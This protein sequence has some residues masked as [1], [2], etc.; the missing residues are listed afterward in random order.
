M[1]FVFKPEGREPVTIEAEPWKLKHLDQW[2]KKARS[3]YISQAVE[4]AKM[5]D[6]RELQMAL[7]RDAN[8]E[9]LKISLQSKHPATDPALGHPEAMA[10]AIRGAVEAAGKTIDDDTL[11]SLFDDLEGV[12]HCV[13]ELFRCCS[14]AQQFQRIAA[15]AGDTGGGESGT[16]EVGN[17]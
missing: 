9:A 14:Y 11:W 6:D 12:A 15:R 17:A 4:A 7:I 13:G 10:V 2:V 1:Q 3:I 5:I 8:V 16:V